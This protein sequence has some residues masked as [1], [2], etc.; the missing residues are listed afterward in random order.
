MKNKEF[1][2]MQYNQ[3]NWEKQ[4]ETK[5]N[6][7]LNNYIINQLLFKE[8]TKLKLFD[9]GFGVGFFVNMVYSKLN[10]KNIII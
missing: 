9:M 2:Y 8:R 6:E 7:S 10:L 5:I 3:I 1:F 4:E